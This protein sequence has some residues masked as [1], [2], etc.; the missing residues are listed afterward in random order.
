MFSKTIFLNSPLVVY[1][2]A[3]SIQKNYNIFLKLN[4]ETNIKKQTLC[5]QLYKIQ[6]NQQQQDINKIKKD[7]IKYYKIINNELNKFKY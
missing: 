1:L 3:D 6:L 2:F 4:Q 5:H 7:N